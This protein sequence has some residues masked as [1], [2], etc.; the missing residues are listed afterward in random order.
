M[1][2]N[3]C[4]VPGLPGGFA[5]FLASEQG[6]QRACFVGVEAEDDAGPSPGVVQGVGDVA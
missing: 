6:G 5:D 4:H 1:R 2:S 3:L